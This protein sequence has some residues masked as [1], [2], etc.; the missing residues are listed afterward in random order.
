LICYLGDRT[1]IVD[2]EKNVPPEAKPLIRCNPLEDNVEEFVRRIEG[3]SDT[4]LSFLQQNYVPFFGHMDDIVSASSLLA[5]SEYILSSW[6][7]DDSGL[8]SYK[9]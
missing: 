6:P 3:N 4:F 8:R 1:I 5:D 7:F 2:D 9:V